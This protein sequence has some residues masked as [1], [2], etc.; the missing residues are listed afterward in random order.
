MS[1]NNKRA[2]E[3][4]NGTDCFARLVMTGNCAILEGNENVMTGEV[5][6]PYEPGK[7]PFQKENQSIRNS[8]YYPTPRD[9]K[10]PK[11]RRR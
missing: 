7:C 10:L 5:T 4:V 3:C 8:V 11:D 2:F 1:K 6:S 9:L